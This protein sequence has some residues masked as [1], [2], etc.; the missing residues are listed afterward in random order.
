MKGGKV[1]NGDPTN[2]E[3][4]TTTLKAL[5]FGVWTAK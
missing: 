4:V 2:V 1:D 3:R 5:Q